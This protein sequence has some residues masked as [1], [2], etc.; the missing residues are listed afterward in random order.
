MKYIKPSL[1][2][3]VAAAVVMTALAIAASRQ[4]SLFVTFRNA[5]GLLDAQG[6]RF[7]LWLGVGAILMA[8]VAACLMFLFFMGRGKGKP[9]ESISPLNPQRDFVNVGP[10]GNSPNLDHFNATSWAQRNEWC[11]EGQADDRRPM[12]GSVALSLGSAS[13]HRSA[14]RLSHQAM[15]KEWAGERHD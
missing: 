2:K 5:N 3:F 6:G 13:A 11:A 4:L 10:D 12:N 9:S 7:H 1:S 14:A 15:Y 8:S